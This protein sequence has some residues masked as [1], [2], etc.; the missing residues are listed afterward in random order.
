MKTLVVYH[1]VPIREA[2]RDVLKELGSDIIVLE[3]ADSREAMRLIEEHLDIGLALLNLNLPD[4]DGFG[5]LSELRMSHPSISV[6]VMSAEQ[7]HDTVV[8]ALDAGALGF[9]PKSATREVILSAIQLVISGGVYIPPQVLPGADLVLTERQMVEL[10]AVPGAVSPADLGLT[11]LQVDVLTLI[12]Q[13]KSNKAICRVLDLSEPIVKSH[14]NTILRALK[15]NKKRPRDGDL[16]E[17]PSPA[18]PPSPTRSPQGK[19]RRKSL[20]F[21]TAESNRSAPDEPA[22]EAEP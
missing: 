7:D 1:H 13:G 2:L 6:V 4:R 3:A 20:G 16:P 12:M 14:I 22:D 15:V 19:R 11:E 9:I 10:L 8:K 5:V 18:V 17:A 21:L